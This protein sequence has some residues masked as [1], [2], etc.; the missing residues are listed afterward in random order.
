M[1]QELSEEE[2]NKLAE[3]I[4][5]SVRHSF[6]QNGRFA[7]ERFPLPFYKNAYD[8]HIKSFSTRPFTTRE[9]I[10]DDE[11]VFETDGEAGTLIQINK[12]LA[13]NLNSENVAEYV[14]FYFQKV[15][16]DDSFARLIFT[17]DDM[18]DDAFDDEL[19][20]SL[21]AL[22]AAPEVNKR[23]NGFGVTGYVLLDDT[24]FKADLSVDKDGNVSIDNEEIVYE[25]LP[26]QH[27]ML[28]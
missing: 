27:I 12:A 10:C 1:A 9:Y 22:I 21:K 11:N 25:E 20:E 26:V 14:A 2:K 3:R 19:C 18:I 7:L 8:V 23:E 28:R 5:H 6:I 15:T 4:A 24:L 13:L 17:A 16:I